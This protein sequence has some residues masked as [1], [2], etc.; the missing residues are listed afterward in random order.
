MARHFVENSNCAGGTG[1]VH[2]QAWQANTQLCKDTSSKIATA[3][4]P[5]IDKR[6]RGNHRHWE[7]TEFENSNSAGAQYCSQTIMVGKPIIRMTFH[8]VHFS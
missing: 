1:T 6:G 4:G 3:L 5:F 7:T 8:F 2:R